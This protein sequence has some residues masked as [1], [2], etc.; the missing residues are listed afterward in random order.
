MNMRLILVAA[1]ALALAACASLPQSSAPAVAV[2][3]SFGAG[4]RAGVWP[5]RGWWR[6]FGSA[7]L[8]RLIAEA[9][10]SSTDITA[11]AARVAQAEAQTRVTGSAL[12][13]SLDLGADAARSGRGGG[14]GSQAGFGLSGGASYELDFWGRNRANLASARESLRA[15]IYDQETVALTTVSNVAQNYFA[16]L[17][18]RDRRAIA[19]LNIRNAERVLS[20]VEARVE[21]GAANALDVA[22][23]RSF[24]AG[25]R[26]AVPLIEQQEI[27]ARAALAILLGRPPQG[28]TV[29]GRNLSAVRTPRVT[30]GLPSELLQ[31][32]P[33]VKRAEAQLAAADADVFAARAA[34]FP[35]IGLTGS[36][37]VSSAALATLFDGGNFAWNVAAGLTQPI[38]QGGR[39]T[40][41]L[42]QSRGRQ[43][44]LVENYRGA[45]VAAFSDVD[46][47]L[48]AIRNVARREAQLGVQVREAQTALNLAEERYRAGAEDLVTLLE[49]QRTLYSAQDALSQVRLARLQAIVDLYR[50]LGGGWSAGQPV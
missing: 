6:G 12:F 30:A 40:G 23:Q 19:N 35:S 7:E 48:G 20:L 15:S 47:A 41:L 38:F 45:V 24:L 9:E 10:T 32:R 50:G 3:A 5:E 27:E 13:P 11:A 2:P 28:L 4:E 49:A 37:G 34:F 1:S 18:L 21:S 25:Q 17:S 22:Q 16:I 26:A 43:R 42:D 36:G 14:A 46:V 39:L 44:E 31:R 29:A 33:D 8:D